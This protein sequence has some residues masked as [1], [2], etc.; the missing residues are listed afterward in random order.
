[1]GGRGA[2][3]PGQGY[4]GYG[5]RVY[6]L[7]PPPYARR[8][9]AAAVLLVA[10]LW[11]L[12]AGSTELFPFAARDVPA[13]EPFT[14]DAVDWRPLPAGSYRLPDLTSGTA[15]VA[16]SAGEPITAAVVSERVPVPDGWWA[17]PVDVGTAAAPGSQVLLVVTDP[18]VTVPGVIVVAQRGDRFSMDHSPA[19]VAVPGEMAPLVAAAERAGFLVTATRP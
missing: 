13:G 2:P 15:A 4:G 10:L 9:A 8:A 18:P 16:V 19:V 7:Q 11:D 14:T 1:M 12:R 17:V 5:S 3:L 6:W